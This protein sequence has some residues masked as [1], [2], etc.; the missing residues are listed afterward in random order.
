MAGYRLALDGH[1]KVSVVYGGYGA[2]RA[3][4][5]DLVAELCE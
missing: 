4:H 1:P 5:A 3:L 2:W